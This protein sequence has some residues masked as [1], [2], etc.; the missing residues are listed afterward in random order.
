MV[1]AEIDAGREVP[2]KP[3]PAALGDLAKGSVDTAQRLYRKAQSRTFTMPVSLAELEA[4]RAAKAAKS[5]K[6]TGKPAK[7]RARGKRK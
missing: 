1:R 4:K 6:P 7:K 2:A 3:V 5:E